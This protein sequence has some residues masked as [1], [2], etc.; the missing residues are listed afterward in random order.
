MIV[1]VESSRFGVIGFSVYGVTFRP[2]SHSCGVT[3]DVDMEIKFYDLVICK[4]M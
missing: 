1:R 3:Y 2:S 4:I